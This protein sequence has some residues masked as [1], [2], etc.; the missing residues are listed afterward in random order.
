MTSDKHTF[1]FIVVGGGQAACV[2]ASRLSQLLPDVSVAML[3]A[4]SDAHDNPLVQS[5]LGCTRL[6]NTDLEWNYKT[7][8]QRHLDDREI[9][10]CGGKVVSGSSAVN[11][12]MWCRC[13]S[14]DF[15]T[16]AQEIK[17]ERWN[18]ENMLPY[19]RKIETHY[20]PREETPNPH[21][22]GFDGPI[23]TV[24]EPSVNACT[25]TQ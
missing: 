16:W 3:E 9:Y 10:H 7:S 12:G 6:H 17:D 22:H 1:D 14:A 18:Y 24:R 19:F 8:P 13:H 25:Y 23:K 20:L 11:Y 15:D 5:P 4:G 21:E 2:V